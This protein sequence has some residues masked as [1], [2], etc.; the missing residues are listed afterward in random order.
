MATEE[1]PKIDIDRS[2]GDFHYKVDY[3]YDAGVGLSEKT[4]DY[5][6]EIKDEDEWMRE[7]R[8]KALKIFN[9]KNGSTSMFVN[10][11]ERFK[12]DFDNAIV[13]AIEKLSKIIDGETV[14]LNF[15]DSIKQVWEE[16][17]A[18]L[19]LQKQGK[20]PL[21]SESNDNIVEITNDEKK[22]V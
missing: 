5:I 1:T 4:V 2:K 19:D 16:R 22:V 13:S 20:F 12:L 10:P 6:S 9:E 8:H 14:N 21:S 11:A 7:F 3:E 18:S 15:G 17:K